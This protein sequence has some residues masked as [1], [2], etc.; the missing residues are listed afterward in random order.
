M[1]PGNALLVAGAG[2]A[3]GAINAVAGGGTLISFPALLATGMGAVTANI[4]SSV[5]LISG[6]A[7]GSVAYRRELAGQGKRFRGLALASVIGGLS[8]ALLLLFTP[9]SAFKAIVPYLIL[10]SCGLL[11][12]QPRLAAAVA[13]RRE[14]KQAP[15]HEMTGPLRAGVGVGAVYGSY[16][17]A[18]LGVLL[19]GVLGVLLDDGLQRLNALKSLLSLLINVVGVLV[20][21]ISGRVAWGYAAILEVTAYLGGT[22]G[23]GV[24]RRLRPQVLRGAVV[25]LGAVVASLLLAGV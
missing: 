9:Q 7:G 4:T 10:A 20:F 22:F 1:N 5:G 2:L 21:L 17:G 23:V 13:G 18:G 15:T 16:F 6:Y 12:V 14:A 25:L 11:A 3:A 19:L 8:G 24:A